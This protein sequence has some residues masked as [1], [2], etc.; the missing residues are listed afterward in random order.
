MEINYSE[1]SNENVNNSYNNFDYQTYQT[2]TNINP[3]N[4]WENKIQNNEKPKK[5]VTFDDILSNMNIVVN[6]TGVLQYMTQ[7]NHNNNNNQNYNY[8]QVQNYNQNY[9]NNQ[10]PLDPSIKQSPIYN[11][12]FK[13]YQDGYTEIKEVKIP[14]TKQEYIQMLIEEKRRQYLERARISQIKSKKLLFTT[15][16][17]N[18]N[19]IKASKNGLNKMTFH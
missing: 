5:K 18:S 8:N 11:K 19:G 3:D 10:V 16:T 7:Q 15:N 2:Q 17:G 9:N 13:N 6:K 12:Y 14:K 1:F 4:Y